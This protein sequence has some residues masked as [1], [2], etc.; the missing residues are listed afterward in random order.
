MNPEIISSPTVVELDVQCV[1]VAAES[2]QPH[3]SSQGENPALAGDRLDWDAHIPIAPKRRSGSIKVELE[4]GG[5]G[6]PMPVED[7]WA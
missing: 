1:P 4:F 6:K 2:H 3:D 5:R 7:P